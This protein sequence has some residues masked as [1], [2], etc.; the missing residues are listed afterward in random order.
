MA[1]RCAIAKL[2]GQEHLY[3]GDALARQTLVT[4]QSLQSRRFLLVLFFG[5]QEIEA[6]L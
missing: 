4:Y 1:Q 6:S 5:R 3:T 2:Q